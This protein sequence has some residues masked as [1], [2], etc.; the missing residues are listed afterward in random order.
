MHNLTDTR[1]Q[2]INIMEDQVESDKLSNLLKQMKTYHAQERFSFKA[3]ANDYGT[4]N[5]P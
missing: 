2:L 1:N 5:T 4:F 3:G